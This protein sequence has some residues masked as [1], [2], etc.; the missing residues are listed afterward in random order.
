MTFSAYVNAANGSGAFYKIGE[1][2]TRQHAQGECALNSQ[3]KRPPAIE[4]YL[5]IDNV[6]RVGRQA[7]MKNGAQISGWRASGDIRGFLLVE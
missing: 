6:Q 5:V 3:R 7:Q 1:Y 4:Q 2:M